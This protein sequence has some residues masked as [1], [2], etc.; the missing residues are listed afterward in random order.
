M[1]LEDSA[2]IEAGLA[3]LKSEGKIIEE[4]AVDYFV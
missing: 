1:T 2:D 4:L 3:M